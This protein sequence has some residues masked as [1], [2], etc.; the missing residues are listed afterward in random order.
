VKDFF[1]SDITT[2]QFL[3]EYW[4]QKPLLL[5][6][7]FPDLVNPLSAEELAGLACE[8]GS[9]ARLVL[10]HC[11]DRDWC[12][13]YGPFDA[14]R[15]ATLPETGWSLL[16]SDV[17]R[18]IPQVR[19]IQQR[20]RFIPDWRLDD[21]MISYA[22]AGGSVGQH[23]DAY[24][25]FLLQTSGQRRW[26]ISE[27]YRADFLEHTDLRIL[28]SFDAEQQWTLN[29]GDMLYLPPN[30]AHHGIALDDCMTCSIG[31]RAP[32]S[33]DMANALLDKLLQDKT[34]QRYSDAATTAQAHPAEISSAS[35][36]QIRRLLSDVMQFD[37]D[38]LANWFGEYISDARSQLAT[39]ESM[40]S[41]ATSSLAS[42]DANASVSHNPLCRFF[43]IRN[44]DASALLFVSGDSFD[45]SLAFATLLCT[46]ADCPLAAL[47][48]GCTTAADKDC[49]SQL[50][51]NH[52]LLIDA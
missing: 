48:D 16:V 30:V 45:V 2:E 19:A 25:V 37:D 3:A 13:E 17:E 41:S 8:H 50:I 23:I 33:H 4:Q 24:D 22:P 20:F 32:S 7:A 47:L 6:A 38:A 9:N 27:N 15:F 31:F 36:A 1:S 11:A 46:D 12:V 14:D 21:V 43:F 52:Y 5:R 10:E 51:G 35:L 18:V 44:T 28:K 39:H 26:Q 34:A 29:P 40:P 49:L 42:L